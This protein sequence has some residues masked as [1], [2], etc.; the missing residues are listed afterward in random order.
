MD[1]L[2]ANASLQ[3]KWVKE[4]STHD[5]YASSIPLLL[6]PALAAP[7]MQRAYIKADLEQHT[8]VLTCSFSCL[9]TEM[10]QVDSFWQERIFFLLIPEVLS[11]SFFYSYTT[12]ICFRVETAGRKAVPPARTESTGMISA[13]RPPPV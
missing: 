6:L 4:K 3:P 7:L 5:T 11:T 2:K 13:G 10:L 8:Y 12:C 1:R 9:C